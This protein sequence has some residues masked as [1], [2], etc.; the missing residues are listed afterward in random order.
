MAEDL[1]TITC[2]CS[3]L[4]AVCQTAGGHGWHQSEGAQPSG[5]PRSAGDWRLPKRLNRSRHSGCKASIALECLSGPGQR[6]CR[7]RSLTLGGSSPRGR[8]RNRLGLLG[9]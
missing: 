2:Y 1:Q 4:R 5:M 8:L 7:V 6:V 9:C 3:L